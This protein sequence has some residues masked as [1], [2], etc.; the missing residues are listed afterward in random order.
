MHTS[1]NCPLRSRVAIPVSATSIII[2]ELIEDYF[3]IAIAACQVCGWFIQSQL[4]FEHPNIQL[5]LKSRHSPCF[6][7]KNNSTFQQSFIENK[8]GNNPSSS[9]LV[10]K[11]RSFSTVFK[12]LLLEKPPIAKMELPQ[13][14][15]AK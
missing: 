12:R 6:V 11:S 15:A 8:S 5:R 7:T 14:A 9:F 2:G 3:G 1:Q 10:Q 4:Q 13:I